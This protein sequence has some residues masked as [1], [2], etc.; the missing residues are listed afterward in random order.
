MDALKE[1]EIRSYLFEEILK[2][3]I[4]EEKLSSVQIVENL[5]KKGIV[6]EKK[7][8]NSVL[9]SEGRRYVYYDRTNYCYSLSDPARSPDR[10][11]MLAITNIE[12]KTPNI[13]QEESSEK[14]K[15]AKPIQ[16]DSEDPPKKTAPLLASPVQQLKNYTYSSEEMDIQAFFR[17]STRGGSI[18]VILNKN[19]PFYRRLVASTM[20]ENTDDRNIHKKLKIAHSC[21]R[22]LLQGWA[23]F[24]HEQPEGIRRNFAQDSRID[25]GRKVRDHL[26][27]E[28]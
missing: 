10:Q 13:G 7:L 26:F 9:F 18:N 25:W 17:A 1:W 12:H 2:L 16:N 23:D 14:R 15:K 24:E 8:V 6:V 27:D 22:V 28:D 5:R 3:L 11:K 21:I 20:K 19:H 4:H